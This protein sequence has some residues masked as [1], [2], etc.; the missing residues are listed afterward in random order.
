MSQEHEKT[1]PEVAASEGIHTE[2]S[3][4]ELGYQPET[5]PQIS[6]PD[7]GDDVQGLTAEA[8]AQIPTLTEEAP[9]KDLVDA[10]F[11]QPEATTLHA[12]EPAEPCVAQVDSA[13][14]EAA[15]HEPIQDTPAQADTWGEVLHARMGKLTD[16][17]H[18]LNTRLDRLEDRNKTKV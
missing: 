2:A 18:T 14:P 11:D 1:N 8:L 7:L 12:E 17:I 5:L 16:D 9:G 3:P 10:S 6:V 15:A 4:F 13:S